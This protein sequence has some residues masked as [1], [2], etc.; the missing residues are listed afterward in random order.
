MEKFIPWTS[1]RTT[2][3]AGPPLAWTGSPRSAAFLADSITAVALATLLEPARLSTTAAVNKLNYLKELSE[4]K[5]EAGN[6]KQTIY[7][8]VN[9]LF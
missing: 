9:I 3:S 4:L 1:A 8:M 7:V 5:S 2:P 6:T